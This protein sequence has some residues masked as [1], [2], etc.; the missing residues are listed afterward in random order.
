MVAHRFL[1]AFGHFFIF[2]KMSSTQFWVRDYILGIEG[3]QGILEL[4]IMAN[5]LL[6]LIRNIVW[7]MHPT[8]SETMFS[9]TLKLFCL[10]IL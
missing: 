5:I 10:Y 9:Q 6:N 7:K 8:N 1:F 4:E 3:F 2:R